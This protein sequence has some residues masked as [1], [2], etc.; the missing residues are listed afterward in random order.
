MW[1]SCSAQ[2]PGFTRL[3]TNP[4]KWQKEQVLDQFL[5]SVKMFRNERIREKLFQP[6]EQSLFILKTSEFLKKGLDFSDAQLGLMFSPDRIA[7]TRK[8]VQQARSFDPGLSFHDI[9]Q[10]CRNMW[11]M[12][13][14]QLIMGIP[15]Q[16]TPSVFAYSM[17]YP[18]TDNLIDDPE[19]SPVEKKVFSERFRERLSGYEIEPSNQTEIAVFGLVEMI[20]NQYS[21]TDCPEVFESLLGIH[22]AQTKSLKLIQQGQPIS[23]AE[24]LKICLGKGGASVL[25]DGFLVAGK[26]TG[27]QQYFLFGFGAYLQLLDD[28]QDVEEDFHAGLMTAFSEDLNQFDLDVKLNKTYWF[29]EQVLK[30]LEFFD[31]QHIDLFKSLV[32]KSMDLFIIEAIA[33]NPTAYSCQYRSDMEAFSPFRFSYIRKRKDQF[34]PYYEFFLTAIEEIALAEN[35]RP[36]KQNAPIVE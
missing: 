5:Q 31:G 22:D 13:G 17:L 21:R 34:A 11:I 35:F 3:Y 2:F 25:A 23:E 24:I 7:I 6:E 16:L 32:R 20:E 10:A 30:N 28:I 4:E 33:Q 26:L 36:E 29:G 1:E 19:I 18:Y 15:V 27:A 8:F 12:N 14:L 9:F